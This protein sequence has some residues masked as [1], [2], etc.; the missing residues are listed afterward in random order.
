MPDRTDRMIKKYGSDILGSEGM[1]REKEFIQHGS[2]SVYEHSLNVAR[3]SLRIALMLEKRGIRID[4]R[5]L[6]RGALLH[7]YFLYDW[8][9]APLTLQK[10]LKMHGFT[11][12]AAALKNAERDFLLSRREREII[13]R[14]M[15]PLNIRPPRCREAAIVCCADK[16]CAVWETV[17]GR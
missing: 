2:V 3:M 14:H 8:H 4:K 13:G 10:P 7:D 5:S 17:S 15:F 1:K 6:V 9:E 11:H 16:I 12:A